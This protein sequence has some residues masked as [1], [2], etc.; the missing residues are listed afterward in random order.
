MQVV[1]ASASPRRKELLL[2]AGFE[3]LVCPSSYREEAGRG[4]S[5]ARLVLANARGKCRAVVKER[6]DAVPV[7]GADTVVVVDDEILGKPHTEAEAAAMLRLL[8]GRSH[9]VLTGVAVGYRGR[10]LREVCTTK[11]FFRSLTKEEITSYVGSGEPMDKAGAY[12][13]QGKGAL[14]AERIEGC[15]NNVVGLPLTELYLMLKKIGALQN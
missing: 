15:Y 7:V 1:L 4:G 8:S 6:G 9:L 11:V 10:L 13:I 5:P 2:Q 3:P 12:G 14:L